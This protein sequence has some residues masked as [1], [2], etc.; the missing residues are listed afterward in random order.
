MADAGPSEPGPSAPGPSA[1][2][3]PAPAPA[4][5]QKA[6]SW[7]RRPSWSG[8]RSDSLKVVP[9]T[10]PPRSAA[11]ERISARWTSSASL[12]ENT[13][14]CGGLRYKLRKQV[15]KPLGWFAI[16]VNL[17]IL[18]ATLT[19]I[20]ETLPELQSES[21]AI[22]AF[23]VIE[24]VCVAIFTLEL[25][26]KIAVSPPRALGR[27]ICSF[28]TLVD[29][30]AITPFYLN[31]VIQEPQCWTGVPALL[32]GNAWPPL[33][34]ECDNALTAFAFLRTIRLLRVVRVLKLGNF[35]AGVKVFSI[36][37]G[38]STPQ[39][40]AILFF[41]VLTM[42]VSSSAM[43]Y[44]EQAHMELHGD[45]PG[46]ESIPKTFY[47]C[48]VTM[49]TVGYGDV[50]PLSPMGMTIACLTMLFAQLIFA[51][52]ITVI[53]SNYEA[54]Y[55]NEVMRRLINELQADVKKVAKTKSSVTL[56]EVRA[57]TKKWS[58]KW[59]SDHAQL[60]ERLEL[61]W[62]MYDY[63][64]DGQ[65]DGELSKFQ[66]SKL[67]DDLR[68]QLDDS[69]ALEGSNQPLVSFDMY[70]NAYTA[71]GEGLMT[72]ATAVAGEAG[73]APTEGASSST[74][75]AA[76]A[77]AGG[78]G[79]APGAPGGA[80]GGGGGV[81]SFNPRRPSFGGGVGGPLDARVAALEGELAEQSASLQHIGD[82][83][84]LLATALDVTLPPRPKRPS[85]PPR[86][87]ST[88][89]T[90]GS[91]PSTPAINSPLTGPAAAEAIQAR[92]RDRQQRGSVLRPSAGRKST[93]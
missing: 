60:M 53:G 20:L 77:A 19:M 63:K 2:G 37:I 58:S 57:I 32:N 59:S 87:P 90:D 7:L 86:R 42:V 1:P 56:A 70:G 73:V 79:G 17:A 64:L 89:A 26:I 65:L 82:A 18:I 51:M 71:G 85:P 50:V 66:V 88:I 44:V 31:L 75:A 81:G 8:S 47:W 9:T 38:K 35:S 29:V 84:A 61:M 92:W 49:T 10:A 46:F 83:L 39:L 5:A 14:F 78:G 43:Y 34:P 15:E 3:P 27:L 72:P 21:D 22:L 76:A 25:L 23:E 33:P 13:T 28:M 93:R 16:T 40:V 62:D 69:A 48:V 55:H 80:G 24:F 54:A 68:L 91:S 45:H 6:I 30:G 41:M 74:D 67:F 11:L 52:P 12:T 4:P 36:A